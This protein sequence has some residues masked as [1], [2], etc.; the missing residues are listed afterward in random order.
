MMYNYNINESTLNFV[1]HQ[2]VEHFFSIN[3]ELTKF[4]RKKKLFVLFSLVFFR[5]SFGKYEKKHQPSHNASV[6]RKSPSKNKYL[7]HMPLNT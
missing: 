4:I 7:L 5:S 2:N 6:M 3:T 1:I